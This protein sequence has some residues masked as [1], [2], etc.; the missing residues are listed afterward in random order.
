M[1]KKDKIMIACIGAICMIFIYVGAQLYHLSICNATQLGYAGSIIGGGITLLGVWWT[2]NEQ[3]K[4][5]KKN[6]EEQKKVSN[7]EL[8][9]SRRQFEENIKLQ[10][11]GSL[12]VCCFYMLI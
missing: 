6:L 1:N 4:Q 3:Q 8:A 2:L 12:V 9:E 7:L 10:T 11:A 5:F